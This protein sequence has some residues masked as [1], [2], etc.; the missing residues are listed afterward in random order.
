MFPQRR[1]PRLIGYNYSWA[2]AYFVTICAQ[3]RVHRFGTI[4]DGVMKANSAGEI[5][6][7]AWNEMPLF[8]ELETD[9]F[10]LMPNHLHGIVV[11][12]GTQQDNLSNVVQ[13]FKSLTTNRYAEGVK[14]GALE[15]FDGHLWQRSFH[16]HIIRD[17]RSLNAIRTYIEANP[18]AW[19]TDPEKQ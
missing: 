19:E 4:A 3:N 5:I 2:R 9:A 11:L 1:A 12:N 14:D 15:P 18:A 10:V 16:E 7:D 17:E 8:Y 6:Q 13:K